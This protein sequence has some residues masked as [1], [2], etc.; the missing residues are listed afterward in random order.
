MQPKELFFVIPTYRLREVGEAI[1]QYD[2]HFWR[3]G[4]SVPMIVFDDSSPTNQEKYYSVLEQTR[5]HNELYYVG[6][7]EKEQFLAY[8]NSRLRDP[9]LEGLVRNLFRPSYGGNRNCALMYT[10]GALVVSSDDDMRPYALMEDSPESLEVDEISRGRLHKAGHNHI[11]HKS[12]DIMAAFK[13]VLGKP[14][15]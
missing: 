4:H 7:A 13:D 12:F 9:R 8:L 14:V 10:L 3:N 1:Q 5:T 6:P 2:E 11:V 15:A